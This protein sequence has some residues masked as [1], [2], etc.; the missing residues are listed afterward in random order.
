MKNLLLLLQVLLHQ[1]LP[2]LLEWC[3]ESP[4]PDLALLQLRRLAEGPTRSSNLAMVS[5]IVVILMI[6]II[7]IMIFQVRQFRREEANR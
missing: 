7:P 5:A 2:L 4:D 3:S 1:L 6:A